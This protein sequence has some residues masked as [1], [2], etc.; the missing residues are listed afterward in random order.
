MYGVDRKDRKTV[1]SQLFDTGYGATGFDVCLARVWPCFSP[2]FQHYTVLIPL[3]NGNV[4]F[5]SLDFFFLSDREV[6]LRDSLEF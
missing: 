2:V 6:Q 1:P 3:W 5:V 4:D